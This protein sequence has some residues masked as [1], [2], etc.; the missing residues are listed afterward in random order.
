MVYDEEDG[1]TVQL[2]A[3][4][5]NTQ[6]VSAPNPDLPLQPEAPAQESAQEAVPPQ[7]GIQHQSFLV[8]FL[9]R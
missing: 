7:P 9:G 1:V 4:I 5:S 6:A 8:H 2:C 3:L